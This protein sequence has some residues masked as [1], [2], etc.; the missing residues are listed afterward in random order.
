ML[1]EITLT[2][3]RLATPHGKAI[4]LYKPNTKRFTIN[5]DNNYY[6]MWY[7]SLDN[8]AFKKQYSKAI[9]LVVD[10]LKDKVN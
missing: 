9:Q 7:A 4:C 1:V 8:F 2:I 3:K 5:N 10:Y 6:L